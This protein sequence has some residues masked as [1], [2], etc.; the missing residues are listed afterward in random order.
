MLLYLERSFSHAP[1]HTHLRALRPAS[2][3]QGSM[4]IPCYR[5]YG[6]DLQKTVPSVRGL[7]EWLGTVVTFEQFPI[8]VTADAAFN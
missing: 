5:V 4:P 1:Y 6:F 3:P 7:N 2:A 8:H